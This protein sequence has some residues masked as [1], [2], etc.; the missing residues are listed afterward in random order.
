[1]KHVI[2]IYRT[3]IYTG[4]PHK[5]FNTRVSYFGFTAALLFGNRGGGKTFWFSF[6]QT[7]NKMTQFNNQ[8]MSYLTFM[9]SICPSLPPPK[10][11]F[12]S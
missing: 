7:Y 2:N 9:Y 8:I 5:T 3:R 10:Q 1:M 12:C 4:F 11:K 6:I